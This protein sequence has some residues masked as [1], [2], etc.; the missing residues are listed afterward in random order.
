MARYKAITETGNVDSNGDQIS[1]DLMADFARQALARPVSI[2][3]N[4]QF[5][6]RIIVTKETNAG[7]EVEVELTEEAEKLVEVLPYIVPAFRIEE[8]I[9]QDGIRI[10]TKAKVTDFALT[11]MPADKHLTKLVKVHE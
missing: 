9:E 8:M 5:S 10:I 3:F 4:K 6:G 2:Q 11:N 1:K 7:V